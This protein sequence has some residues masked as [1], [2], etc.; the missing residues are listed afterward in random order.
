MLDQKTEAS[1]LYSAILKERPTNSEVVSVVENNLVVLRENRDIF[2]ST[3]WLNKACEMEK[4]N[5]PFLSATQRKILFTNR[6]IL[7]AHNPHSD[8]FE[9]ALEALAVCRSLYYH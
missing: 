8:Q 5:G 4:N 6:A 9:P 7:L 1:D 3:K 2:Q